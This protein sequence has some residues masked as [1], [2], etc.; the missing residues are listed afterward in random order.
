MISSSTIGL[1]NYYCSYQLSDGSVV[2]AEINDTA[3]QERFRAIVQSYYRAADGCL[4]VYDISSRN[5]FD[6]IKNYYIKEIL[7]RCPKNVKVILLGNKSDLESRREVTSEE[8][9]EIANR[10]HFFFM[11]SSCLNNNNI[12]NGFQ[13]LIEQINFEMKKERIEK[14]NDRI[15]ITRSN[16][17]KPKK[18]NCCKQV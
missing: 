17:T 8:A 3:G 11:E 7:D 15:K 12:A 5:S 6:E 18:Q 2:N 1:Q 10:F 13:L 14:E 4:L 9:S 16:S